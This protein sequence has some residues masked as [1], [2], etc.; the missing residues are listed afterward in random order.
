M[1]TIMARTSRNKSADEN[2]TDE[3]RSKASEAYAS[4]GIQ[5]YNDKGEY[6]DFGKT[7]DQLSAKWNTLTDA[8]R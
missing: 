7:L 1:K 2:V 8:Q 5:L 6:Q 3:E 4:V